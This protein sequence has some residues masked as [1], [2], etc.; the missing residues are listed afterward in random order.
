M[1]NMK[2]ILPSIFI[3]FL[4]VLGTTSLSS[5]FFS[6]IELSKNN[7]LQAGSIDLKIDNTSYYNGEL[8]D[9]T[10]WE[11]PEDLTDHLFLN[12]LDI[13]PS[14]WGEDTISIHIDD[15]ESWA[16]VDVSLTS[17][18]DN[19]CT[20]PELLDD[21]NC[22]P[23][24]GDANDGE[25]AQNVS[26][27]FW[28]DDGDN[29]LEQ[30]EFDTQVLASGSA[31]LALNQSWALADSETNSVGGQAGEGLDP[32]KT[33]YIGKYWCF[34]ELTPTPLAD[35]AG[36]DP[37]VASGFSCNGDLL[38]NKTQTDSLTADF[39]FRAEQ[40]RNNPEFL[41]N[42]TEEVFADDY[43]AELIS[44]GEKKGGADVDANRSIPESLLGA[45]DGDGNAGTGFYSLGFGGS[46]VVVFEQ[47][48]S[49]GDG[50]DLSFHEITNGRDSYPEELAT[51]E[52]SQ[53]GSS[54]TE[55]GTV[56]SKATDG[57]AYLDIDGAFPS[58]QYVKITDNTDPNLHQ[59]NAD[60]YD[61]DA[62]DAVF[63]KCSIQ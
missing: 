51:I 62:I 9:Q 32:E 15:N 54:W 23:D 44:Q 2:K 6:D 30:S 12:F 43:L 8:N 21:P 45:P 36:Q 4:V 40:H 47:P 28:V 61:I 27:V 26:F 38:N 31:D 25:L 11:I 33:Y 7:I 59:N 55:I 37:T 19:D 22:V 10:T 63:G 52:V 35:N 56:S 20:E 58:I 34:G 57:V 17:N 50:V 18:D 24:N 49:D 14:D 13:K 16:C 53:D 1:F 29:V 42:C 48:V 5:A 39:F 3:I 60:G 41:C 46:V